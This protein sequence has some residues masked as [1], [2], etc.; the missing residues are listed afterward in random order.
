MTNLEKGEIAAQ[1]LAIIQA[2]LARPGRDETLDILRRAKEQAESL[3]AT[4]SPQ[5]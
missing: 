4:P 1:I 5:P 2:K 3:G